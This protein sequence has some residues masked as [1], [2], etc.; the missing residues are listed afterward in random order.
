M[1]TAMGGMAWGCW[2]GRARGNLWAK[3][4][5][6]DA[7]LEATISVTQSCQCLPFFLGQREP[8]CPAG[9]EGASGTCWVGSHGSGQ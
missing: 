2:L 4:V 1:G 5:R 6:A 9:T 3:N 7:L 8:L